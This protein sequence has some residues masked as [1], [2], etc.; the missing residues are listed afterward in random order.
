MRPLGVGL[1]AALSFF[2]L[3]TVTQ[4]EAHAFGARYDLPL[5]LGLYL[6]AAGAAV[7]AS[8]LGA[9]RFLG[10]AKGATSA[11]EIKFP[12]WA[13]RAASA[14][15][16]IAGVVVLGILLGAA[17]VGPQEAVHNLATVGI[18]VIW[19]VGFLLFSALVVS[20]WPQVDPF[21][22]VSRLVNR[23]V[24]RPW[25]QGAAEPPT[26]AGLVAPL[27]LLEIA[28]LQLLSDWSEIPQALGVLVDL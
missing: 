12:V 10:G 1:A 19:W 24:G 3:V 28:S 17:F 25:D 18:W 6:A 13:A 21:R 4:A 23:T 8:F 5:P 9:L 16:G 15:F 20:L 22:G 26:A 11:F 2:A 27:G 7:A 14:L